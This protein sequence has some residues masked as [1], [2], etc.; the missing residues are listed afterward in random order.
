MEQHACNHPDRNVF[1]ELLSVFS[2]LEDYE[3]ELKTLEIKI[4]QMN[5][6]SVSDAD[7]LNA[8]IERQT[9]LLEEYQNN[10]GLTYKSRTRS[11]LLG[12]GFKE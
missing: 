8:L 11:S 6:R 3:R 1:D 10:G 9:A 2:Y 7:E 4:E 12:L 5:N